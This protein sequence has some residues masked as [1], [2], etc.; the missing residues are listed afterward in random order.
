MHE[1]S[2]FLGRLRRRGFSLLEV[3]IALGILPVSLVI[4]VESQSG[5]VAMTREAERVIVAT[6]LARLKLS[7]A[8]LRLEEEGFQNSEVVEFGEFDDLGDE[9][10]NLEFGKEYEDYHWEYTITEIDIQLAGDLMSMASEMEGGGDGGLGGMLGGAGIPGDGAGA[11]G[12]MGDAAGMLGSFLQPQM[13]TEMVGPYIRM[14]VVRVW[15]GESSEQAAEDGTEVTLAAH[16][17]NPAGML[18]ANPMPGGMP[19]GAP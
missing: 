18:N 10:T 3:M 2:T 15:W 6:D 8:M 7:E 19:G 16:V 5:A 9:I 4:L 1:T 14:V 11:G 13:L 17:A 12:G